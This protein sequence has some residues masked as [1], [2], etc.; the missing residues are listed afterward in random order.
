MTRLF[1]P[2]FITA[3]VLLGAILRIHL[4]AVVLISC[5]GLTASLMAALPTT[6]EALT[7][8]FPGALITRKEHWLTEPQAQRAKVLA[9]T[10]LSGLWQV[11]Y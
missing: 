3:S 1:A 9:G 2:L 10:P 7:L 8:I 5:F 4:R 6:Q 11:A